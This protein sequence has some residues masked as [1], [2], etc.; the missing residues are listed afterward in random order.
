M[1]PLITRAQSNNK[2][3]IARIEGSAALR[4]K[5]V[6]E[7]AKGGLKFAKSHQ[8]FLVDEGKVAFIV[9]GMERELVAGETIFVPAGFSFSFKMS[10]AYAGIY[11]FASGGGV[12]EMLR[13][14]GQVYDL[15]VISNAAS[16]EVDEGKWKRLQRELA[17]EAL[18]GL[19][20]EGGRLAFCDHQLEDKDGLFL[21]V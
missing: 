9:G 19:T 3:S 18:Y 12:E 16:L 2:F 8:C 17:F 1:R 7:R 21:K 4:G 13:G 5:G 14:V 20:A 11:V 6:F 10:G 15:P